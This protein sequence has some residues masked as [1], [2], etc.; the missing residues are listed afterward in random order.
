MTPART[1]GKDG[2]FRFE[3]DWTASLGFRIDRSAETTSKREYDGLKALLYQLRANGQVDVLRA[4]AAG[5]IPIAVLKQSKKAGRLASDTLMAD[6]A[7]LRRL[8]HNTAG[9]PQ[10]EHPSAPHSTA[11]LGA[12]DVI[13]PR[14]GKGE[15]NDRY[16]KSFRKLR[17]V[18]AAEL[19]DAAL[20]SD[21]ARVDW[22]ALQA[23]WLGEGA[24]GS[25]WNH[26]RRAI[27]RFLSTLLGHPHH[28]TRLEIVARIPLA[29]EEE[30]VPELTVAQFWTIVA[31]IPEHARPCFVVLAATMMRLGEY[32]R[33]TEAHL[34]PAKL[35][36]KVP[37]TKSKRSRR[38][39]EVG[40]QAWPF[41]VAGIP[42]PLQSRWIH[43]YWWRA[44]VAL[45]FGRYEPVTD[46]NGRPVMK[47]VVER[48][49][50]PGQRRMERRTVEVPKTK[51]VG[52]R[53]HDLR[54][55]GAQT[56][57]DEG[58][59]TPQVGDA[60]GHSDPKTTIRYQRRHHAALVG[61]KLTDALFQGRKVG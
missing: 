58:A 11:C 19:P 1:G 20:V 55:V 28:P 8:W 39:V 33:C 29:E 27:S 53:I 30:R 54:H 18:A 4:F 47:T 46:A 43:I 22:D 51:Y 16:A 5:E 23:R 7:M 26:L 2:S 6:L 25:D 49:R 57:T 52:L 37:G 60:L 32:L 14:M 12:V 48:L 13:L 35:A 31:A 44:C 3:I 50:V 42:S 24:S 59:T 40:P 17:R 34:V 61:R 45:G 21:L 9:C 10:R 41:V 36:V 56:A 38:T 15:T